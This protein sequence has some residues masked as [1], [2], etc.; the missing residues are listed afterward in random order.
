MKG[1]FWGSIAV[2]AAT[3]LLSWNEGRAVSQAKG[4]AQGIAELA[5]ISADTVEARNEKRVVH[6]IGQAAADETLRDPKL[7]VSATAIKL[8][9]QVEMYQ[10]QEVAE[11]RSRQQAD[12]RTTTET[13][14][15]Y[16]PG[17][18]NR[19]IDSRKFRDEAAQR[20]HRNPEKIEFESWGK[21]AETVR[22]GKFSL[23]TRLVD[24]LRAFEQLPVTDEVIGR[25]PDD[26]RSRAKLFNGRLHF[27]DDPASPKVGDIR[28]E[29]RVVPATTVSV[30]ARQVGS[31]FDAYP[32]PSGS[33]MELL[34]AGR[35]E[36]RHM[37][38]A[39][40]QDNGWWS[41]FVRASSLVMLV[42]GFGG[43][44]RT[45]AGLLLMVPVVSD[46]LH[47]GLR[48]FAWGLALTVAITTAAMSWMSMHPFVCGLMLGGL[49]AALYVLWRWGRR[50]RHGS[51]AAAA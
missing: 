38:H 1:M 15:T 16:Q 10:W 5:T 12:G 28:F 24:Q 33:T 48:V 44:T 11:Q 7:G 26:L 46:M 35:H 6:L 29:F 39:V 25:L 34:I 50:R 19:I 21:V 36:A 51:A 20:D 42:L 32:T 37:Y 49:F 17:W 4:V 40:V 43:I 14:Y 13:V 9:R 3:Y 22:V 23:S 45:L 31:T 47:A 8:E 18:S 27:A 30:I 2:V 41:W